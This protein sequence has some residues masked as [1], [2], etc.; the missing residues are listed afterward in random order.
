[1]D[2]VQAVNKTA[3][4]AMARNIVTNSRG[5]ECLLMALKAQTNTE[6]HAKIL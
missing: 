1:V 6:V 5:L 2:S 3:N 4:D